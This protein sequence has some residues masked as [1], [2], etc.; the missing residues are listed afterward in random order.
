MVRLLNP[1]AAKAF[2]DWMIGI[3]AFASVFIGDVNL[4]RFQRWLWGS[5]QEQQQIQQ[6]APYLDQTIEALFAVY[7]KQLDAQHAVMALKQE[8][9][10]LPA[11]PEEGY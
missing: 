3:W 1:K 6:E 4:D 11:L 8:I 7:Q 10:K 5:P 2:Y 9:G